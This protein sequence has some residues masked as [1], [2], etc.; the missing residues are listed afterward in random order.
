MTDEEYQAFIHNLHLYLDEALLGERVCH[1]CGAESKMLEGIG[2]DAWWVC[3]AHM[4]NSDIG[5]GAS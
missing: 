5:E 4:I 2:L 3:P 1:V